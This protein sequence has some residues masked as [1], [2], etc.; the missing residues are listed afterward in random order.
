MPQLTFYGLSIFQGGAETGY[1][2]KA[3][4]ILGQVRGR[5]VL[6]VPFDFPFESIY[7]K[8]RSFLIPGLFYLS[9]CRGFWH[10][11]TKKKRGTYRGGQID[12]QTHSIKFDNSDDE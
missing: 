2:A 8:T 1:G 6:P 4:E 11:K 5:L 7:W 3:Q 9:C 12:L 10:E